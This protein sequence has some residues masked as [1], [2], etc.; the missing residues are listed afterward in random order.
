MRT[1]VMRLM[2]VVLATVGCSRPTPAATAG[3]GDGHGSTT[4]GGASR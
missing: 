1:W 3:T 4:M 2:A